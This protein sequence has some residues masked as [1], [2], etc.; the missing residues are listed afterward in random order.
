MVKKKKEEILIIPVVR[1]LRQEDHKSKTGLG[2]TVREDKG[3]SKV[4]K[5]RERGRKKRNEESKFEKMAHSCNL[6]LGNLKQILWLAHITQE[7]VSKR[8]T[9]EMVQ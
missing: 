4:G 6:A 5:E 3:G 9:K 2:Y 7:T 8:R 1:K